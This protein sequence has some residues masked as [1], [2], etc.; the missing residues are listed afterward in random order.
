LLKAVSLQPVSVAIEAD[1]SVFQFYSSGVMDS[2]CGTNL[3][4]GVLVVGWGELNGKSYWK[5]KNSWGSSWGDN[6]YILLSRNVTN[7]EGQCGIA[8][9]ASY[10]VIKSNVM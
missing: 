8:M 9:M 4:H 2:S 6:G 1:Q 5:V 10:P 3:D 7:P